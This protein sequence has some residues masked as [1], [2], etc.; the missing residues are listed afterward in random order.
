MLC[1]LQADVPNMTMTAARS[2]DMYARRCF[3]TS[4]PGVEHMVGGS[5]HGYTRWRTFLEAGMSKYAARRNN[6]MCRCALH[7]ALIKTLSRILHPFSEPE[8]FTSLV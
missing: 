1:S 5:S 3:D 4:V 8:H 2:P 7:S 6:A